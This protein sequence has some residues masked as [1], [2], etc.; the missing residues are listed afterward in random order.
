MWFESGLS[1]T[2]GLEL[3]SDLNKPCDAWDIDG[4]MP[5]VH[6]PPRGPFCFE[7][8]T[9]GLRTPC[10]VAVTI[11]KSVW[12]KPWAGESEGCLVTPHR[13]FCLY[14]KLTDSEQD[15]PVRE[16]MIQEAWIK[17]LGNISTLSVSHRALVRVRV[18]Q[19]IMDQLPVN[20]RSW[21]PHEFLIEMI[22]LRN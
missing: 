22:P 9:S 5:K 12:G 16:A 4:R 19:G 1:G 7:F 15:I 10:T 20:W 13:L 6:V 14:P 3:V 8:D 21:N 2:I 11:C 17:E 18:F